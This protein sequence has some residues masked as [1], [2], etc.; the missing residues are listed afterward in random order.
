ME[1]TCNLP[2]RPKTVKDFFTSRYFWI[3]FAGVSL[4][5][6]AGFTYFYFVGCNSGTCAIT[7][8]PY[9]SILWGAIFG[10]FIVSSPCISGKC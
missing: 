5:A 3:P 8:N 9:T 7:N 4:G 1:N 6:M 10:Y 2:P